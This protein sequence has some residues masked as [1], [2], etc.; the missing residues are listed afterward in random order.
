VRSLASIFHD[1]INLPLTLLDRAAHGWRRRLPDL[2][3]VTEDR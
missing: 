1:Q 3:S 2:Q